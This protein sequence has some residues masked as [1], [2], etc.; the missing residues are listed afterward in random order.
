MSGRG[1]TGV[2]RAGLQR[3]A[4]FL[5]VAPA[6]LAV[7]PAGIARAQD[8]ADALA[9]AHF[10][11]GFRLAAQHGYAAALDE[12]EL[13]YQT[14]PNFSVLY[15]IAQAHVAL[16]QPREAIMTLLRYLRDGEGK[17]AARRIAQVEAQIQ[18]L[19]L[20]L[21]RQR[22]ERAP[23][24]PAPAGQASPDPDPPPA[25]P[26]ALAPVAKVNLGM[27]QLRL[28]IVLLGAPVFPD[29]FPRSQPAPLLDQP[30]HEPVV[31]LQFSPP[32]IHALAISAV[33]AS[34]A[35]IGLYLWNRNRFERWR[36]TDRALA[37][38][39]GT[40]PYRDRQLANNEFAGS[41]QRVA[42]LNGA[43]AA[44]AGVF[45]VCTGSMWLFNQRSQASAPAS[46]PETPAIAWEGTW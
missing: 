5:L 3:I 22:R 42:L 16:H 29:A 41:I 31:A 32:L 15:N 37:M 28:P 12:F 13:A 17:L 1:G 20:D 7:W 25:P 46:P 8:A 11:Q 14:S 18:A 6:A 36:A 33:S 9:R 45:F 43:L 38:Q 23:D 35:A 4:V 39:I 2:G 34:A 24:L 26:A 21:P 10:D 40:P 19:S 30:A 27:G 44:V